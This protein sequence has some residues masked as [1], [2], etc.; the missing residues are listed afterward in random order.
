MNDEFGTRS[1]LGGGLNAGP[2]ILFPDRLNFISMQ[3]TE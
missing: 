1:P 2:L 3:L